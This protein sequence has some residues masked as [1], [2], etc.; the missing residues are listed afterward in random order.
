LKKDLSGWIKRIDKL[1]DEY[2]CYII[3]NKSDCA[4]RKI[5]SA[6]GN[7]LADSLN[8]KFLE[9]SASS[10]ENVDSI[11][12]AI[13]EDCVR[14]NLYEIGKDAPRLLSN[15]STVIEELNHSKADKK[16]CCKI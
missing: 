13:S 4:D 2:V 5:S 12:Q 14:M 3:G 15:R 10:G 9:C 7:E 16:S 1:C 8:Y 6:Q 11:F